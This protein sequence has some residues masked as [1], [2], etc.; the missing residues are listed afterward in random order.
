MKNKILIVE[1]EKLKRITLQDALEGEGY[2]VCSVD[3]GL[4][5][6]QLIKNEDW[7]LALLDLKLPRLNGLSLLKRIRKI[8]P[9]TSIIVMTAFGTIENAV[10]AMKLGAYDYLTKPF[11]SEELIIKLRRLFE[12]RAKVAEN[13]ALKKALTS[14]HQLGNIIGV[15]KSMQELFEKIS[16][17]AD[18]DAAVLIEGETGT[19]K[20]LI[21]ETIHYNSSR[22]DYTF[23]KLSCVTLTESIIESEL[24]GHEKGA[25][26]GAIKTKIG[27]FELAHK[28]TLFLDDIEDIPISIQPKLLRVLQNREFE[29]V[30]GEKLIKVNVR[31]IAAT[32]KSLSS[33]ISQNEFREDLFYRLKTISIK[34]PPLRERKED[35]PL[36]VA[37]F[38]NI[39]AKGQKRTFSPKVL[40]FLA[41]YAWPGNVRELEHFVE[42]VLVMNNA[43]EIQI[44]HLPEDFL[45]KVTVQANVPINGLKKEL[46][47]IEKETIKQTLAKFEGNISKAARYLNIPRSTLRDHLKKLNIKTK[48]RR[49]R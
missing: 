29:R 48:N 34:L 46:F 6:L 18:S 42:A 28:G 3:D 40:S 7:D 35:I 41:K 37:H 27:R 39:Y 45:R 22:R 32:K 17:V 49:P 47:Q 24:F 9:N 1:D 43:K 44:N 20:E 2:E 31:V 30:G 12:Y 25:F 16:I 21:A 14:K 19:G 33:L 23:I 10:E 36:L 13:I 11:T 38:V 8:R 15:S 5:G 4:D 26:S